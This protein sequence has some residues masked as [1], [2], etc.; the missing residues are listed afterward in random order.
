MS[1]ATNSTSTLELSLLKQRLLS[2]YAA[3]EISR[4][5]LADEAEKIQPPRVYRSLGKSLLVIVATLL[6]IALVPQWVR[7]EES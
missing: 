2:R 5:E 1:V 7:R 6:S 4:I 3:G